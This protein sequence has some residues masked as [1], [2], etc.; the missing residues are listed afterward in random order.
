M[1]ALPF[2]NQLIEWNASMHLPQWASGL[3]ETLRSWEN[4]NQDITTRILDFKNAGGMLATVAVVGI[5]TGF[6]EE[7]FFRGAL[8]GVFIHGGVSKGTAIWVA[9]LIFSAIHFQFF[10]FVPRLLMGAMFG[11]LFYW[12]GSIWL[13]AFAHALNN[14]VVVI[15]SGIGAFST[16]VDSIGVSVGGE[17]PW[18]AIASGAATFL[19]LLRFRKY[20]FFKS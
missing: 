17:F 7:L 12:S 5:A 20:F 3:E 14:S 4:S 19:F 18:A 1:L 15:F 16:G 9:A 6:S 13:P 10:G 2:M 8:Q 11:Y